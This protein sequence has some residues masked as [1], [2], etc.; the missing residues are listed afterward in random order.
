MPELPE[1]ETVKRQLAPALTGRSIT[2]ARILDPLIVAPAAAAGFKKKIRG[3][4]ITEVGR[5]GKYL[6]VELDSGLTLVLH[7]RM[8][9]RLIHADMPYNSVNKR[10]LRL[11]LWLDDGS[12]LAFY[13]QRRFGKAVL[14]E[15]T[16]AA[17][18]WERLG[19]EP[20]ERSFSAVRLHRIL[21][22]RQRP[23]KSLLLD[24]SLIAGI[25]NIYA[26]EALFRAGINPARPANRI[27]AAEAQ[28]LCR[29]IKQTL[30]SAIRLEGS[31]VDTYRTARGARGRFQKTF[32]VHRREGE[33]C[34]TCDGTVKKIRIAGRSTYFCPSCQR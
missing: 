8:T 22:G 17:A 25:G 1:V 15:P 9:G 29:A 21:N 18:L 32:R 13:D 7:L 28:R 5:R 12:G 26:D 4:Q 31:S 19:P 10:H 23:V 14:L 6:K 2:R 27:S 30:R 11:Y 20:L 34:P 16:Q 24:Q 3:R 33:P